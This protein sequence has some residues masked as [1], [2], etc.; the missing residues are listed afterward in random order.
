MNSTV[1][2]V[3]AKKPHSIGFLFD[4]HD[5]QQH[6]HF[7][8]LRKSFGERFAVAEDV[9]VPRYRYLELFPGGLRE[10]RQ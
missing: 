3:Y 1:D 7:H 2:K 10:V 6:E 8:V 9:E 4:I 5:P